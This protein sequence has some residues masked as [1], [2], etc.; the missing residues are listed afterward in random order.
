MKKILVLLSFYLLTTFNSSAQTVIANPEPMPK[1]I[2]GGVVNG[3]AVSLPK[4]EYPE[5]AKAVRAEGEVKVQ[6]LIDESGN[7]ISVNAIS[8][9]PLLQFAAE[10]AARQAQFSPTTLSGQ[11]VKVSGIIVYKFILPKKTE[12]LEEKL[13]MMGLAAFLTMGA[14]VPNEEWTDIPYNDLSELGDLTEELAQ[15]VS[16]TKETPK[17]VRADII[18]TAIPKIEA[19]LKGADAWQFSFGKAFG[20]FV[21]EL[22]KL[23]TNPDQSLDETV[24]KAKLAKINELTLT[25][26]QDMPT[27]ILEKFKN[28]GKLAEAKDLN[29]QE[30]LLQMAGYLEDI[31]KTIMPNEDLN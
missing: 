27:E 9:H 13:K 21:V 6:V 5:S 11:P 26:P 1:Q 31:L 14:T 20:E 10:K 16:I 15:I 3:K 25:A 22:L 30:S 17:E 12:T 24:I 4:P 29:S 18:Q 7:I 2:N 8:G 19:K 23:E 28:L